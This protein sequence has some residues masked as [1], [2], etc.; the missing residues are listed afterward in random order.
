[1]K[2]LDKK[3][4]STRSKLGNISNILKRARKYGI[5]EDVLLRILKRDKTC[6]YCHR[7]M[8]WHKHVLGTPN[9]K[10]TIEHFNHIYQYAAKE[11][12]V[13]ICCGECNRMRRDYPLN[14][15]LGSQ[16]CRNKKI[17]QRTVAKPIRLYLKKMGNK[18]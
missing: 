2:F 16:Y 14:I 10:K 11:M 5:T 4:S 6:I 8:K 7:K 1:M 15:W 9:D 13:G 3:D 17:N 12:E 18:A